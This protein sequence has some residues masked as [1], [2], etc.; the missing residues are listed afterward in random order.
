MMRSMFSGIS[1]LR[2]H[3]TMM[4]VVG[5]NIAN[6]NT[7]GYKAMRTT[8]QESLTQ[9]VRGAAGGQPAAVGG[10][11]PLQLGLGTQVAAVEGTFGQGA[12][13]V[14]GRSTDLAIQGNGFFVVDTPDGVRF[15]R[16]GAFAW[17]SAGNL[18]GPN[19]ERARIMD[20]TGDPDRVPD[21][22]DPSDALPLAPALPGPPPLDEAPYTNLVINSAGVVT[23]QNQL[24]E[25]VQIAR[26]VMAS[27]AN[28]IGL[29]RVGNGVYA[30]TENSGDPAVGLS[31]DPAIGTVQPGTLEMSNVDLAQE[32]TSMILAQRG[33]QA[34]SRTIS[35]TDEM[36]Q[37]LVNLKR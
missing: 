35:S 3:Q 32:F 27:F 11:N 25:T 15:S 14:T 37:D 17:D 36:L 9:V 33:F 21:L 5:N 19:G 34:N 18:V 29:E 12:T 1:G 30:A 7:T 4:D 20:I 31:G 8:F 2:S 24:G 23:G 16:A 6:V 10:T 22:A 28:P 13:M 26:I